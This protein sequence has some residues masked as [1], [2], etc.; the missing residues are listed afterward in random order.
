M[1]KL[2]SPSKSLGFMFASLAALCWALANILMKVLLDANVPPFELVGM[3]NVFA[4]AFVI[5]LV[6]LARPRHLVVR[7]GDLLYLGLYGT[8]S[9]AIAPAVGAWSVKLNPVAVAVLLLYTSP[10]FTLAWLACSGRERVRRYEI[11]AAFIVLGG[12]T[13]VARV[14][15]PLAALVDWPAI[16]VGLAAAMGFALFTV[17]GKHGVARLHPWTILVYGLAFGSG[18]WLS[19][20]T[21]VSFITANY[22]PWVW[23]AT[24]VLAIL[25]GVVTIGF[26]LLALRAI[27]AAEANVT[28]SLEP[29]L[30]MALAFSL[31][32]E[33]LEPGQLVGAG[34][35]IG[36]VTYLQGSGMR[37]E[38]PR[39]PGKAPQPT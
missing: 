5:A 32:G 30:T 19:A 12:V 15:D 17:M 8:L 16:A 13:L 1:P 39:G 35:L 18:F 21:P 9:W 6:G 38:R 10:L 22:A 11:V 25:T 4:F 36:G 34:I 37:S 29:V 23:V 31:L 14:Y 24:S 3:R 27:G 7:K 26:Y 33:R 2:G 20:G 28:A